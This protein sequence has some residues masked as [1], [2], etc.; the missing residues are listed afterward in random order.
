MHMYQ[1]MQKCSQTVNIS[2]PSVCKISLDLPNSNNTFKRS[3]DL[4]NSNN[5][6]KTALQSNIERSIEEKEHQSVLSQE[7]NSGMWWAY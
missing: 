6:F 1:S 5:V 2:Q 3:S 4:P 7:T